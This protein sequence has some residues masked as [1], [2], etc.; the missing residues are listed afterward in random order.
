MS[1]VVV[2][3]ESD[4]NRNDPV[5]FATAAQTTIPLGN[6]LIKGSFT[7]AVHWFISISIHIYLYAP[8]ACPQYL[9]EPAFGCNSTTIKLDLI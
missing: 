2:I 7:S 9:V 4:A 3:C 1:C 8:S 6:A 5:V